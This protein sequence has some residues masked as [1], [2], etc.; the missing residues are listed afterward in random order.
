VPDTYQGDDSWLFVLVDPDNRSPLDADSHEAML[1]QL[2]GWA[3]G[4][5]SDLVGRLLSQWRSGA[6]KQLVVR[7]AL[8]TRRRERDLFAAGSYV[9]LEVS[10][11]HRDHVVAFARIHQ[12]RWAVAVVPRRVHALAG[13]GRFPVGTQVWD[14]AEVVLPSGFPATLTDS[15]TGRSISTSDGRLAVGSVLATLPVALLVGA[16]VEPQA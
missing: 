2:P 1:S 16:E 11:R 8:V 5:H 3:D 10:G 14:D 12:G 6:V 13:P 15:L 7:N 9:P 4:D